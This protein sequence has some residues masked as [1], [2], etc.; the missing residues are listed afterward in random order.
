VTVLLEDQQQRWRRGERMLVEAYLAN[1]GHL[2]GDSEAQLELILHEVLLRR[3]RGEAPALAEYQRRFPPLAEPLALQ[4]EVERAIEGDTLTHAPPVK[5]QAGGFLAGRTSSAAGVYAALLGEQPPAPGRGTPAPRGAPDAFHSSSAAIPLLPADGASPWLSVA[6][7]I[8]DYQIL[9][10]LGRGGMG[11][12]Y[13]ARHLPL[14]RVVALKMVLSGGHATAEERLRFLAEAEAIAAVR[15]PG[16]V[17]VHDFGTHHGMPFF[18]L[19][20]CPGGSLAGKLDG[21]PLPAAQAAR[22]VEQVARAVQAAHEKGI[23]HRDL[24]PG[25]ILLAEDGSPKV[26]DFGLSKRVETGTGLTVT[27]AVLGTPGYMAPEQARGSKDVGPAADVHALGAILY[28]LLTGRPPFRAATALD[29]LQ[30]VLTE[31]PIPPRRRNAAVPRDLQTVCLKCLAKEPE[32][33]YSSAAA[34]ANDLDRW[35]N[36]QPVIAHPP[37][38]RYR[39]GKSL[40]HHRR[41]VAAC[42]GGLLALVLLYLALA[43]AGVQLP[44]GERV[45]RL[46]D[47]LGASV[48]RPIPADGEVRRAAADYR[49]ELAAS[50]MR[51]KTP[52]GWMQRTLDGREAHKVEVWAHSTA[53][54]SLF[55][56]PELSNQELHD[57]VKGLEVP[58]APGLA[59]EVKGVKYGWVIRYQDTETTADPTLWLAA[60]LAGALARPGLLQGDERRRAERN[61]AYTQEVVKTYRPVETGGW[62]MY[63]HQKD[64]LQHSPYTTMV[65]LM[66]LLETRRAGLPWE[67]SVQRRDELLRATAQYLIDTYDARGAMPGWHA[68]G[69]DNDDTFDGLTLQTYGLLL[70]AEAEAGFF[71]P[72]RILKNIPPHLA[73]CSQ[74]KRDFADSAAKFFICFTDHHGNERTGKESITFLWYPWAVDCAGR[75]LRRAEQHGASAS[76]LVAVRRALAHLVLDLGKERGAKVTSAWTF[77]AAETLWGLAILPPP[78]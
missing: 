9:S 75:W 12:V 70:R 60:A 62:N 66:A 35:L 55:A 8:P 6:G 73:R 37:S 72:E 65:A 30:K 4:F 26:T 40:R 71:V 11:V 47:S 44:R 53:L 39:L 27:G 21:T 76:D 28:E 61:L 17:G 15:H 23:V 10:E 20:Y 29:T 7:S 74:R 63:P 14:N 52:A 25:N 1:E 68:V 78:D 48:F 13:R 56:S 38:W 42:A 22:L 64:P 2:R 16:I 49:K 5:R 34:L 57:L 18:S 33:R 51:V 3:E 46:I 19:E 67:G 69:L 41:A 45:R 59:I 77:I 31:D 58:F 54:C 36:G 50:L 43:D 32:Q 24:K